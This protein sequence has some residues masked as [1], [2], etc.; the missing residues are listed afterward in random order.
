MKTKL[1]VVFSGYNE[2]AII[3][4]LRSATANGIRFAI[5]A[6]CEKDRIFRTGYARDVTAVRKTTALDFE[7]IVACVHEVRRKTNCGKII[8]APSSEALN[9]HFLIYRDQY[10][11]IG[12]TIPLVNRELYERV[13]DK[14]KFGEMCKKHG[15][16]VPKEY[17]IEELSEYPF[18]AKPRQYQGALTN[19][20]E[21]PVIVRTPSEKDQ[22][23]RTYSVSAYYFQEFVRG[24]SI[25]LLYTIDRSGNV[26]AFSQEN[27]AQQPGGKSIVAAVPASA[28]NTPM[29]DQFKSMLLTE[30][31]FGL[32]MIEVR[33]DDSEY[34]MI[35]ANPRMWGPSQLV[36]DSKSGIFEAFFE[37]TDIKA[38]TKNISLCER[39]MDAKYFWYG[40]ITTTDGDFDALDYY[41][42]RQSLTDIKVHLRDWLAFDMYRRNDTQKIYELE[43]RTE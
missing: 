22:F 17:D 26:Q 33:T 3:A 43:T 32:I 4:L 12:C 27:V 16:H 2:R 30:G 15:I 11:N 29:G 38:F 37:M 14:Y 9:R 1:L 19:V 34:W 42:T 5:I 7:D 41:P 13:S 18:V 36:V 40:G 20:V 31:F 21:R 25:Y 35:E 24:R 8:V 6:S 10:A 39:S 23:F 28:H